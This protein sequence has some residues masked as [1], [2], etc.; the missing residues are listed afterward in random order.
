MVWPF[1]KKPVAPERIATDEII[2]LFD[3]DDTQTNRGISLEYSM[4]F[5]EVLDADKLS[6][7]LWKLFEKPGW[8]KLGGRLRVNVLHLT[9]RVS[10]HAKTD[11]SQGQRQT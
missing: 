3:R 4:I 5:Y 10:I 2:P 11:K 6:G 8:R 1:D 9:V 7:T